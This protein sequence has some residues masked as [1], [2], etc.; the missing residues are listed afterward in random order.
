MRPSELSHARLA[1]LGAA[2]LFST[3]GVVIKASTL[4]AF[5]LA[6]A[7][8]AVAVAVLW[9]AI[10][11]WRGFLRPAPLAVGLA[12]GTT[13]V[14]FIV[15][16]KLTTAANAIFLQSTAPLYV[17]VLGP[18]LLGERNRRLD[19]GL[20][21]LI[22]AGLLLFFVDPAAPSRTAPEPGLGNLVAAASG[23]TWALTLVGLRAVARRDDRRSESLTGSAVVAGNALACAFCAAALLA[24]PEALPRPAPGVQD[25]LLVVYLGAFQI[26]LAYVL[27]TRSLRV[28]PALEASL[29]LLLEPVLNAALAFLV[30][31]ERPGPFALA[32]GL[33]IL[34]TTAARVSLAR[35]AE[36]GP[37][38][39]ADSSPP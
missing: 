13:L 33:L 39:R 15:A 16:N 27:M 24:L 4:G 8:S 5:E 28:L 29:L 38:P 21:L 2:F 20:A 36:P 11:A 17:L 18:W 10:P 26:G 1:L 7:R 30:H 22:F 37:L 19:V 9:I 34:A 12:Y 35:A 31:G 25:A 3:G 14:L 6:A 32:G 23:V